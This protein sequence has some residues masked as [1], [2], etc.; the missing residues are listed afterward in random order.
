M[1]RIDVGHV[2]NLPNQRAFE[3]VENVLHETNVITKDWPL[4]SLN[5]VNAPQR[6]AIA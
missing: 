6:N 1:W 3:H 2:F 4:P 5:R